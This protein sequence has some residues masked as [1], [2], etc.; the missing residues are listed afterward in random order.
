[1][2]LRSIDNFFRCLL[3]QDVPSF[4]WMSFGCVPTNS[5][6]GQIT[7]SFST[8]G[9]AKLSIS[10]PTFPDRPDR[11]GASVSLDPRF[12]KS[13]ARYLETERDFWCLQLQL[14]RVQFIET[15][16]SCR[17]PPETM[18]K[19]QT[20]A[21][22]AFAAQQ[23][24]EH[25]KRFRGARLKAFNS[26]LHYELLPTSLIFPKPQW[27]HHHRRRRLRWL[28][29]LWQLWRR[30]FRRAWRRH[31][32]RRRRGRRGRRGGEG[33][34]GREGQIGA[35]EGGAARRGSWMSWWKPTCDPLS[36]VTPYYNVVLRLLWLDFEIVG[37]ERLWWVP[38]LVA[39]IS[40]KKGKAIAR[41]PCEHIWTWGRL[42]QIWPW[43]WDRKTVGTT[44]RYSTF[45]LKRKKRVKDVIW[46]PS[47]NQTWQWKI[48]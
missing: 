3:L 13:S 40:K 46:L 38:W 32:R 30:C 25:A 35:Y 6:T 12:Q 17:K 9:A 11:L 34:E 39:Q 43:H 23:Q 10:G 21:E 4:F 8:S 22:R 33:R 26:E 18:P 24:A 29:R 31:G 41:R 19:A 37:L 44:K 27:T 15:F 2:P 47:G 28:W 7:F 5:W 45:F 16:S 20:E 14:I 48:L 1:M 42:T 36:H